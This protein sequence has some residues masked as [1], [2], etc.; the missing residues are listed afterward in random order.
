MKINRLPPISIK[1]TAAIANS[2]KALNTMLV[3]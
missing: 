1:I 3:G 2:V